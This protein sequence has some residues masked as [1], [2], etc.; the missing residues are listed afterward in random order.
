MT[1]LTELINDEDDDELS[2]KAYECLELVGEK[3]IEKQMEL[4][5]RAVQ[6]REMCKW[7]AARTIIVDVFGRR[8]RHVYV[9]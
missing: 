5:E 9:K 3:V 8:E 7:K 4:I 2:K 1:L 6:S